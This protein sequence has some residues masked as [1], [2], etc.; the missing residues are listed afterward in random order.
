MLTIVQFIRL[1]QSKMSSA[2][3]NYNM[4]S[5]GFGTGFAALSVIASLL[6]LRTSG[7]SSASNQMPLN[8]S[9][10]LLFLTSSYGITMFASSY[11]EEEHHY[12]HWVVS[13]WLTWIYLTRF[14][15]GLSCVER[16]VH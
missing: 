6:S 4:R 8:L 10:W 12:W 5:L 1:A 2:A 9:L 16:P 3:A 15:S 14:V 13:I 11:V 7:V